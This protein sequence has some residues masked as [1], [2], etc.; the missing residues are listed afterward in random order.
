MKYLVDSDWTADYLAGKSHAVQLLDSLVE[1]GL[2][3]S[4]VTYGE[5][6]EGVLYGG[7]PARHEAAL[8]Q[9]L[10]GVDVLG[11]NRAIM[12]R[13]ATIRGMLREQGQIIGDPDILIGAT[14]LHHDLTLITRN[15]RHFQRIPNLLLHMHTPA[16]NS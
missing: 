13:F 2:S 6:Y 3:I 10:R 16:S 1:D 5:V 7:N 11:L 15:H 4:I 8:R 12:R 9:F 14:A